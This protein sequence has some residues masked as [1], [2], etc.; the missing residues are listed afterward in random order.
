MSDGYFSG[1]KVWKAFVV[2]VGLLGAGFFVLIA[3]QHQAVI[4]VQARRGPAVQSVYSTGT[5]EA[6]A[7][8]PVSPRL[9]GRLI[10]LMADEGQNVKKNDIL[11]GLEDEDLREAVSELQVRADLARTE[12]ERRKPLAQRGAASRESIDKLKADLDMSLAALERARV[13]LDY[14]KL[15]APEDGTVIRRDG[16]T[17]E[18]IPAGQ[19]VFWLACCGNLRIETEVDE[20]DIAQVRSGQKAV[21]RADAFPGEVFEG[22]V[23]TITP[24]GDPVSRSYRVRIE[25]ASDTKLMIGMTAETNIIIRED[26]RALL[27]PASAVKN[28]KVIVIDNHQIIERPIETGAQTPEVT[29]IRA[30]ITEDDIIVRD[31]DQISGRTRMRKYKLQSWGAP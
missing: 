16:E 30:G 5:V 12:Y 28:H 14:M 1:G 2:I 26:Q 4:T 18:F 25:L 10:A 24:K 3:P 15:I 21:V 9:S 8:L 20:E 19:P 31:P 6:A 13:N 27:L 22:I 11:A 17:R 23:R 29:E 7:M